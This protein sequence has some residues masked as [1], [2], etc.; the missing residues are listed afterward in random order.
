M[1]YFVDTHIKRYYNKVQNSQQNDFCNNAMNT[2]HNVYHDPNYKFS[3][4][5]NVAGIH[6]VMK[7]FINDNMSSYTNRICVL[8]SELEK[9]KKSNI[10]LMNKFDKVCNMFE[11]NSFEHE[12]KIKELLHRINNEHNH[13]IIHEKIYEVPLKNNH[14]NVYFIDAGKIIQYIVPIDIKIIFLSIVGGG[15]AGGIGYCANQ[16]FYSGSGGGAGACILKKPILL[17]HCRIINIYVG[18]GGNSVKGYDGE[19]SWIEYM[20]DQ[21]CLEKIIVD[22]GENGNPKWNN[23]DGT[24]SGGRGGQNCY[25][26]LSGGC[27]D[28]GKLILPNH[29]GF[30]GIEGQCGEISFPSGPTTNT[31][32]GGNSILS[33]GGHGGTNYFSNG[34]HCGNNINP[35]GENGSWGSGGGGSCPTYKHKQECQLSGN[36]GHGFIM[37]EFGIEQCSIENNNE[38]ESTCTDSTICDVYQNVNSCSTKSTCTCSTKSTCSCADSNACTN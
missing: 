16:Y 21:G 20:N 11:M 6:A 9:M 15:G 2:T 19:K 10:E 23:F 36:G 37:I 28:D 18:C 34:G 8:T 12:E 31:G 35:I 17:G 38:C 4:N 27:G 22:G 24:V 7:K 30:K 1:N 33:N 5:D 32:C 14:D 25:P 26:Y 13:E 3:T 29:H